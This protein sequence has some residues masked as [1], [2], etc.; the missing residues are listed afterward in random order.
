[1]AL[2]SRVNHHFSRDHTPFWFT[3]VD[4]ATDGHLFSEHLNS[5]D[6]ELHRRKDDI[7]QLLLKFPSI[8]AAAMGFTK[9]W[10]KEPLWK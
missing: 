7:K 1:M 9:G 5:V 2:R 4:M 6:R 3:Q 8:D 10:E